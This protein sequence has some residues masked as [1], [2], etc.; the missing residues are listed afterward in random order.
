MKRLNAY[1]EQAEDKK[2]FAAYLMTGDPDIKSTCAILHTAVAAGV[3][4]LELGY[5]FSDPMAEGPVIQLANERALKQKA[6]LKSALAIIQ[7]FR[8]T[9]THTPIILMGYANPIEQYGIEVFAKDLCVAG[10]DGCIVV[11]YPAEENQFYAQAL[12]DQGLAPIFLV[13]PTTP[14]DRVEAIVRLGRGFCYYVSLKGV[15]GAG[16]IDVR[17]VAQ[18]LNDIRTKISLPILVGFGINSP[19]LAKDVA[20]VSDG[21]V[22]G[23]KI[24]QLMAS[25][26]K[27]EAEEAV[28]TFVSA[29][30]SALDS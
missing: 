3:N 25:L 13:S 26:S 12:I 16:H 17:Q 9:N 4:I 27:Q 15:T 7:E 30:R 5:P 14:K 29:V 10:G 1:F 8:Q 18:R 11:D 2:T 19:E 28:H 24:I 22:I 6:S 23:S 20:Q 21:V